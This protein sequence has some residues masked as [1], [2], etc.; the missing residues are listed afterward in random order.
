MPM[1]VS[2]IGVCGMRFFWIFCIFGIEKWH[3]ME[4]LY[5]SYPIS[6]TLTFL[7]HFVCFIIVKRRLDK[8]ECL[9]ESLQ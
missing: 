3:T 7:A 9:K 2:L 6:W 8:K 5:W 4:S 1:I